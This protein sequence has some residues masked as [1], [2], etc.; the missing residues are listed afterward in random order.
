MALSLASNFIFVLVV[1]AVINGVMAL[2]DLLSQGI[3]QLVV[4]NKFRGR[5]MG[6]WMLALGAGPIGT[7]QI[8]AI[9]SLSGVSVALAINGFGLVILASLFILLPMIRRI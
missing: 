4:P 1:L 8:G 2:S 5:A 6:S 3:M 7:L 9:A